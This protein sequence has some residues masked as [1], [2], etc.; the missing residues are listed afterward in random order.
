MHCQPLPPFHKI[1][2]MLQIAPLIRQYH[3]ALCTTRQRRI[4][5]QGIPSSPTIVREKRCLFASNN[6][7]SSVARLYG[8]TGDSP[9]QQMLQLLGRRFSTQRNIGNNETNETDTRG[10]GILELNETCHDK[11]QDLLMFENT[12]AN[13][14][15]VPPRNSSYLLDHPLCNI[16]INV[17]SR[18]GANLHLKPNHPLN[19][20]KSKIEK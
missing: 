17:D 18:I 4:L 3:H 1:N 10:T 8:R 11:S 15:E 14:R 20:I 12:I 5:R 19:I 9:S 2:V 16:P 7:T 13:N 6:F